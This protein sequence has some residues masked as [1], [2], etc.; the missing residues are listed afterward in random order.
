[1]E[2]KKFIKYK[3]EKIPYVNTPLTR[4]EMWTLKDNYE[5][6]I[7]NDVRRGTA[8]F[9]KGDPINTMYLLDFNF[10]HVFY[11]I[12]SIYAIYKFY[13]TKRKVENVVP[14]L[15]KKVAKN[16]DS[17]QETLDGWSIK[18]KSEDQPKA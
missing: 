8:Q 7:I 16:A 4:E 15:R 5:R 17:F 2:I 13:Q 1:M 11:A 3:G 9:Y 18:E 14:D 12:S 10:K 6:F